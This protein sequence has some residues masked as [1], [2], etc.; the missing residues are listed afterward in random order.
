MIAVAHPTT[1][2]VQAAS[3]CIGIAASAIEPPDSFTEIPRPDFTVQYVISRM[4][5]TVAKAKQIV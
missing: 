3:P 5:L 2:P 1:V 4:R